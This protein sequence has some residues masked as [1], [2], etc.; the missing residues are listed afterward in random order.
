[1]FASE[2][3]HLILNLSATNVL[4]IQNSNKTSV[5]DWSLNP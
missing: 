3:T 1:M 2:I 5:L 4:A